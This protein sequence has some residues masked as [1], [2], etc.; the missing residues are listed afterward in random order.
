M[1]AELCE[2]IIARCEVLLRV[3]P[4]PMA[5]PTSV[6][7]L[8]RAPSGDVLDASKQSVEGQTVQAWKSSQEKAVPLATASSESR[9]AMVWRYVQQ[10]VIDDA[11]PIATIERVLANQQRTALLRIVGLHC[12][13]WLVSATS[14]ASARREILAIVPLAIAPNV[15]A[16]ERGMAASLLVPCCGPSLGSSIR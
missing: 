13:R 9:F 4:V 5:T 8:G 3:C 14:L 1:Y 15:D 2:G 7:V 12:F 16:C 11:T 6:P 10:L